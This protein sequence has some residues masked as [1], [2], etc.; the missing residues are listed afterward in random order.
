L[1]S[2]TSGLCGSLG[3]W[4]LGSLSSNRCCPSHSSVSALGCRC[5]ADVPPYS[6][7][8]VPPT[9]GCGIVT[10]S[11][12]FPPRIKQ[13]PITPTKDTFCT[14]RRRVTTCEKVSI[15][16]A[17]VPG[18]YPLHISGYPGRQSLPPLILSHLVPFLSNCPLCPSFLCSLQPTVEFIHEVYL[19]YY[20]YLLLPSRATVISILGY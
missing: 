5:L 8:S 19:K 20:L 17:D 16:F 13:K 3:T 6:P 18:S 2:S 7:P 10:K 15:L 11:A 9:F 4:H 12:C 1:L 14:T